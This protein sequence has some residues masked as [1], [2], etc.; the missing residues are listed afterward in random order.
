MTTISR[1]QQWGDTHHPKWID[2]LRI[3]LGIFLVVKGVLFLRNQAE[4]QE[5][6]SSKMSFGGW[7]V[8]MLGH[9]IAFA[10]L[11]GGILITIGVLTRFACLIQIPIL[12]GAFFFIGAMHS[13]EG[14]MMSPFVNDL[15]LT[16]LTLLLVIYF[17]IAGNGKLTFSFLEE[18]ER[19]Q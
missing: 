14:G 6:I 9:Y 10:H 1:F 12:I 18:D 3:A 16:I 4:L 11:L 13:T 17:L 8:L 15:M 2:I 7:I 5:L 19:N